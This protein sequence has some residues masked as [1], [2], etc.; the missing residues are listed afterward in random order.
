MIYSR[1]YEHKCKISKQYELKI[2]ENKSSWKMWKYLANQ[3]KNLRFA[4][5]KMWTTSAKILE[6]LQ[7]SR[8]NSEK[9]LRPRLTIYRGGG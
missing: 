6:D 8:G 3:E 5:A 9:F 7:E 1:K 4:Q 2:A